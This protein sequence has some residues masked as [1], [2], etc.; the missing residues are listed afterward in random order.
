MAASIFDFSLD[1]K[2]V[3]DVGTY[4]GFFPLYAIRRGARKAVGLEADPE[5]F[6]LANQISQLHGALYTILHGRIE[7]VEFEE[8]FDVVLLLNV[9]HHLPDPIAALK[10][11]ASLC[12]GRL[13]VEFCLPSDR[14]YIQY[15]QGRKPGAGLS[16]TDRAWGVL[17]SW[18]LRVAAH[19]LPIMAVGNWE[20]HK[21][22]YFS[23]EAFYN[24]FVIHHK[25]FGSVTFRQG[26]TKP[27]RAIAICDVRKE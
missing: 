11:M 2:T 21:V 7:D 22:C 6:L 1:G 17:R 3:L 25:L 23:R 16:N 18:L 8:S 5:R 10:K 24:L 9:L 20:Y 15:A 4:Y 19:R 12:R 14:G 13:I 26:L 27:H